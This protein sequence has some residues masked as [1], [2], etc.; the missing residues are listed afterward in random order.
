M[1]KCRKESQSGRKSG[2]RVTRREKERCFSRLSR[3][4]SEKQLPFCFTHLILPH[5]CV[6]L[7]FFLLHLSA[8]MCLPACV[9]G[10]PSMEMGAVS[11]F[12]ILSD[13]EAAFKQSWHFYLSLYSP[14][15]SSSSV[16]S[17]PHF[18]P[19][20]DVLIWTFKVF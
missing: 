6:P 10:L 14:A 1:S 4:P 17:S 16:P 2:E 19:T 12:P 18:L 13:W 8:F 15:S 5:L 9:S 3:P 20:A 7:L 11:S